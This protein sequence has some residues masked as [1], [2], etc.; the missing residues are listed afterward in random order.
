MAKNTRGLPPDP[1]D[2]YLRWGI[3]H[4]FGNLFQQQGS[5]GLLI[6]WK[7]PADAKAAVKF[8][9]ADA[10][11]PQIYLQPRG[12]PLRVP[13]FWALTVSIKSLPG[14]LSS[15]QHLAIAIDLAA[16]VA[17]NPF[18]VAQNLSPVHSKHHTLTAVLDDGC[19]FANERFR[20]ANG[21]R[22]MWL[23]N[24]NASAPGAPVSFGYGA[25]W[26]KADLD[27]FF[28]ALGG[29]QDEAYS[30][31]GLAGLRRSAVHGTHVMDL[32][33]GKDAGESHMSDIVFVQFPQEGIDDPSGRWLSHFAF[34]GLLYVVACAGLATKRIVVNIS[35]GPQTGP[36][37]GT[38]VMEA[39]I[40]WL[41]LEQKSIGRE[42][43]VT[44]AAGNS[45]SA[46]AHACV[47]YAA[48]GSFDWILPPDG[49]IQAFVEFWWPQ[50]VLPANARLRVIAPGDAP[51]DLVVGSQSAVDLSWQAELGQV[52]A[53]TRAILTVNPTG[54]TGV[55]KGR[56]GRWQFVILPTAGGIAEDIDVYV[57]RAD[58]NM[59]ARRRA[60]ASHLTDAGLEKQRFVAA[61]DRDLEAPG[62]AIRRAGTL[63]GIATGRSSHVAAGYVLKPDAPAPYSSSGPTRGLRKVP[64]YAMMTDRSEARAGVRS[65]GVR[66]GTKVRLVGTSTAAPQ[67]G[68]RLAEKILPK[69]PLP[70]DPPRS[71]KGRV[72]PLIS[73]IGPE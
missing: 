40:E 37:D 27:S 59:G 25:Q 8:I 64:D 46:K 38:Y 6:Q 20:R 33:A 23:W 48:G 17:P 28:P 72:I 67:L 58:H 39:L 36:H 26:S 51:V 10:Q 68:R 66:T 61:S 50:S 4:G 5:V 43:I 14:F 56:D 29:T 16:P 2:L 70:A 34:D 31:A 22:V 1:S 65:A 41:V 24:Q 49:E 54:G 42:L 71:G 47:N 69:P 19:A 57:A 32:L 44:L 60:K 9:P 7:S 62:S 52:G 12:K 30:D 11:V 55:V 53:S 73:L 21:T 15:I 13:P 18:A 45:F 35:W 63:S 3:T